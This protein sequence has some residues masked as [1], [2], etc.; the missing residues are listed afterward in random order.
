[1]CQRYVNDDTELYFE[2]MKMLPVGKVRPGDGYKSESWW[3]SLLSAYRAVTMGKALSDHNIGLRHRAIRRNRKSAS[4]G[5]TPKHSAYSSSESDSD[6]SQ[7]SLGGHRSK[8]DEG[9]NGADSD[10]R[11]GSDRDYTQSEED[12]WD[13]VNGD[14]HKYTLKRA[15]A[16]ERKRREARQATLQQAKEAS[17]RHSLD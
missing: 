15:T 16:E 17:E 3:R 12:D 1:M 7:R 14:L 13:A 9:D 4:L 6:K 11:D 2:P 10:D 5:E 8:K